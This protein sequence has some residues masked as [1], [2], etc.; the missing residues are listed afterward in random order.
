MP[1]ASSAKGNPASHRMG[2]SAL[3]GRRQASWNRAQTKKAARRIAQDN[4]HKVN[5][6]T[7]AGGGQTPWQ[8]AKSKAFA[9]W[10]AKKGATKNAG[11][12]S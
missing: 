5:V 10:L 8:E 1:N 6:L 2:N 12:R 3:K 11:N 4:A 7:I 9:R